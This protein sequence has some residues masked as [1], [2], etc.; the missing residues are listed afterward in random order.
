MDAR[1]IAPPPSPRL[2]TLI[3]MASVGPLALNIFLPSLPAMARHFQV[4]YSL[5]QLLLSLYMAALALMQLIMG[6]LSDRYGRRPIL[7]VCFV[8][9]CVSTLGALAAPDFGTMLVCRLIQSA[10]A[11]GLVLSRA[12]IRDTTATEDAATKLAYVTMGMSVTPM[13]A[14][15]IGGYLDEHFGWQASFWFA[16]GFGLIATVI[17]WLDLAETNIHPSHSIG[18]Q[19]RSYPELLTSPRF[20]GYTATAT[21]S[22][23]VFFAFL[24]GGP[25]ISSEM[26]H[27]SPSQYGLYFSLVSLGYMFGNFLSGRFSKVWGMNWMMMA[28]TVV[29]VAGMLAATVLYPIMPMNPLWL[30]LPAAIVGVGNGMTLPSANTGIVSVRPHLAGSAS[31][32]GGALMVAGGAAAA[33]LASSLLGPDTGP[34]PLLIVCLVS[35]VMSVLATFI[36]FRRAAEIGEL[37]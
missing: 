26:L 1:N 28:G 12:I 11:A 18:D 32:L 7:L 10:S 20:W 29:G 23:A 37:E 21:F 27:L 36:V 16:F 24:G 17:I 9:F 33:E 13:V 25:Y 5:I 31:G 35:A 14:P 2:A 4:D 3:L 8:L 15:F 6:P 34:Y 22:S 19:F 30:F